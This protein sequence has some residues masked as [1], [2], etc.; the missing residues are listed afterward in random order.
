MESRTIKKYIS[1]LYSRLG[2]GFS[3]DKILTWIN[4]WTISGQIYENNQTNAWHLEAAKYSHDHEPCL[5]PWISLWILHEIEI[6][7]A[8]LESA[9]QFSETV[10]D[11]YD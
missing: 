10:I 4:F 2:L 3:G 5:W 7:G 8:V 6:S 1:K 9:C 11:F